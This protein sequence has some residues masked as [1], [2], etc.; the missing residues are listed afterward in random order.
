[1][2]EELPQGWVKTTL[3]EVCAMN[4]PFDENLPDHT[5][6]S[7]I[8]MAAV[9]EE[10][11]RL[12]ASLVRTLASVQ[13]GHTPF[14]END[15]V[16]A[17]ITPSMEN[18]KI[19]LAKGLRNGLAYGSTEF[20]VFRPYEVLLPRFLLYFLLGPSLREDAERHMTGAVGQKRVPADYLSTYEFMLPPTSEQER[21][22]AK[23]DAA[24]L[25][26]ER[27]TIAAHRAQGRLQRYRAAVLRSAIAGELTRAWR[28]SQLK[29]K[30]ESEAGEGLLQRLLSIRRVHWKEVQSKR[31]QGVGRKPKDSRWK[32]RYPEPT[33]PEIT[34]LIDLP[35]GW[36]WTTLSQLKIHSLYGPRFSAS[37]YA[38]NGIAVLRTSD[39]DASGRVSLETCPR[40]PLS[41]EDYE[42]YKVEI[43]DLLIT[44][45]GSI[46][47]LAIFNDEVRAI[48]GAY[49]L[50]YRLADTAVVPFVYT[51]FRSP[52]GQ[53]QLWEASAGSGR[54]NLSAPE[55]EGISI[56]LPP[57]DEQ[58]K[59]VEEVE[60]RLAAADSLALALEQQLSRAFIAR[61]SLLAEACTGRLLPQ[62]PDDEPAS[63]LLS[64]IRIIRE[65]QAKA[66]RVKRMQNRRSKKTR[67][68]LLD[69]L[70]E[71]SRPITPEQLFIQ[72]G[73]KPAQVDFFYRELALLRDQL[74]V[75]K[76]T[77]SVAKSWPSRAQVTL[78][79][80]EN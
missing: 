80:K 12:D 15:V 38:T 10:T 9:E 28:E 37:D 56:P 19:A 75:E 52:T 77:G 36:V 62:D 24:L 39:I 5:E 41:D 2:P 55:L 13:V 59:I 43:G 44:R 8:P 64:R 34:S 78:K 51:F 30:V 29:K 45:T 69:V 21:I 53:E 6:I 32:S 22:V 76:P 1:M 48:P 46:G 50:H 66:P 27:A 3:G 49:L 11:G 57:I 68:P 7:F 40:L 16:F 70:R 18:G 74:R 4:P 65:A 79:L 25:G 33:P 26:L 71:S 73:F 35:R 63:A 58:A 67:R 14:K 61:Q 54:Q 47:T 20:F 17:K 42:K 60:R 31:L 72:A 23:L